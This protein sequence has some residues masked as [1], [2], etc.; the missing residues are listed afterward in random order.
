[1]ASALDCDEARL[2]Q[3]FDTQAAANA[4]GADYAVVNSAQLNNGVCIVRGRVRSRQNIRFELRL[5][6][7]WNGRFFFHGGAGLDGVIPGAVG[8]K[9][10]NAG[11]AVDD[12]YAVA[13]TDGGHDSLANWFQVATEPYSTQSTFGRDPEQRIDYGYRAIELVTR[14]AKK[15]VT[16]YY[17]DTIDKSFFVG[18]SNGGRQG[19]MV[20]KRFPQEYDGVL[21]GAPAIN[22]TRQVMQP[23]LDVKELSRFSDTQG[24]ALTDSE[25]RYVAQ[26]VVSAC[27]KLDGV[28][29]DG[30]VG[31]P[32]RCQQV[33]NPQSLK[34]SLFNVSGLPAS[35]VDALT[36][37]LAG[38]K[39]DGQAL[40]ASWMWDPGLASN[41]ITG[42][43]WRTWRME[44]ALGILGGQ[45]YPIMV[46]L[47]GGAL[48]N[49]I[50][51]PP[52]D[53]RLAPGTAREMWDY[54]K[55]YDLR[56]GYQNAN[57]SADPRFLA[58]H[59]V[60]DVPTPH[61][62]QAFDARDGKLIVFSGSSDGAVATND[63]I[64]WYGELRAE[65]ARRGRNSDAY[66]RFFVV[67]GM[68]HCGG[69]LATD[70][71][72]LFSVLEDWVDGN[73]T[74]SDAAPP[75]A[76]VNG[77]NLDA[78]AAWRNK[79]SRPLCSYPRV[80]RYQGGDVESAGS[81]KCLD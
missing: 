33:F 59:D 21:A 49:V 37:I 81:F 73:A 34:W 65:D 43:S 45:F 70:K 60:L 10:G 44:S 17:G 51:S 3:Y 68:G 71:F 42:Q 40:Y 1:M 27:D 61:A 50:A 26:K 13:S 36:R 39:L 57:Q 78:P 8:N 15:F 56:A 72:D 63:L 31:D 58:A 11:R 52:V 46:A 7:S 67:P 24:A 47:G 5:P 48:A 12:G 23:V 79:R 22:I 35:K 74:P 9:L 29:T 20:A 30:M 16:L 77:G 41:Q 14:T 25:M 75:T 6:G 66:A 62:L 38:V 19:M 32:V 55:S 54:L 64:R 28:E 80:A 4:P 53:P 76:F 69:G 18:C 2:R